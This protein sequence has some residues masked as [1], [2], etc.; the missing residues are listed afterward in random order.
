MKH[1]KENSL[2]II[3]NSIQILKIF[4]KKIIKNYSHFKIKLKNKIHLVLII[5]YK[6]QNNIVKTFLKNNNC[7]L[8]K[9]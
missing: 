3:N 2:Y 9:I 1:M 7:H 8:I 4:N 5:K 6:Y